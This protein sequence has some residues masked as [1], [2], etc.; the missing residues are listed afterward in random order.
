MKSFE[1]GY[2]LEQPISQNLLMTVRTLGEFRGRQGLF[3][4]QSPEVLETLRRVAMIQ[5][6]ESSNR[7][8]GVTV[9]ADRLQALMAHK[10]QPRDRS[11]GEIAGYRDVLADIH[12]NA[13]RLRVTPSLIRDFHR[14]MYAR[15]KEK[16]GEWKTKDNA[17]IRPVTR[18]V[19][20]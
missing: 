9:G 6:V 20:M 10:T 16:G 4:K 15:T 12:T 7:I 3:A 11:D 1:H 17:F 8:E 18:S 14:R 13:T 19:G 2:L 5:S